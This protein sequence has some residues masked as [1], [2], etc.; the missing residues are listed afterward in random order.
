MSIDDI[1]YYILMAIAAIG[2]IVWTVIVPLS[3]IVIGSI[4]FKIVGFIW[5]LIEIA[6]VAIVKV[7]D[8]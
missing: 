5:L 3:M 6:A 8:A 7:N 2:M 4:G 1:A